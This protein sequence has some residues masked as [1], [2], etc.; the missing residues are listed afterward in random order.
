[1]TGGSAGVVADCTEIATLAGL[2]VAT[3]EDS[4][5]AAAALHGYLVH[6]ALLSSAAL[7]PAGFAEFEADLLAALDG[8]GGLSWV[9]GG[10][11][12]VGSELRAAAAA[13]EGVDRLGT[14]L[15]DAVVGAIDF[16]PAL[17]AG[18]EVL[19]DT[20]SPGAAAQAVLARDPEL[21]DVLVDV[22][23]FP[24]LVTALDHVLP[25]GHGV[26]RHAGVDRAGPAGRPPRR[27]T[28]VLRNLA[29]RCDDARH[30]EIDVRVLTMPDGTR[31]AIVDI[32]GT[33]SWTPLPTHDVTSLTTNG[34]ALVG[35]RTAYE[36]GVL[37][38]MRRAGVRPHDD[39]MIVGHSEGGMVAVTTARDAVRSGEFHV[40]HVVTAGSPIGLS[41]AS[42][43]SAVRVLALES[44]RDLVPHLDGVANPDRPNVVTATSAHGDGTIKG[45][46][47]TYDSYVA[48]GSDVEASRDAS[49]R[50]FLRSARGYFQG[51][52]VVTHTYQ[53]QRR[54]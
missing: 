12:A 23:G 7:D 13:Y 28:D 46:H 31:R 48:V 30:G 35:E 40:T 38:A 27:L 22:T 5:V 41:V 9:A 1:V 29:I 19:L 52:E 14:D 16:G 24:A 33:K 21:A 50:D 42:V 32:S 44:S 15:H 34:R 26:V 49:L 20:G 6:P 17:V 18:G 51:T 45:D 53:V 2:F 47:A 8:W 25:D 11:L 37:A 43:P 10:C 4:L 36:D 39:V 3:G 54:Y